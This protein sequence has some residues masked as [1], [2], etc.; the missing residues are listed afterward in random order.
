MEPDYDQNLQ[1]QIAEALRRSREETN[2]DETNLAAAMANS[3]TTR[4]EELARS[5]QREQIQVYEQNLYQNA[6]D[7]DEDVPSPWQHV[8]SQSQR[9]DA[10]SVNHSQSSHSLPYRPTSARPATAQLRDRASSYR[11]PGIP[12]TRRTQAVPGTRLA[13]AVPVS[14]SA[15]MQ[16]RQQ[17]VPGTRLA[18]AVPVSTSENSQ[19]TQQTHPQQTETHHHYISPPAWG[20]SPPSPHHLAGGS[21]P[22]SPQSA[23][24]RNRPL[25][26]LNS[27]APLR[28]ANAS[29]PNT[30]SRDHRSPSS[31]QHNG[32]SPNFTSSLTAIELGPPQLQESPP[33]PPSPSGSPRTYAHALVA[34]VPQH[35]PPSPNTQ[36]RPSQRSQDVPITIPKGEP[37][38]IIDGQ[39]VGR[40]YGG[41]DHIFQ[42][43]GVKLALDYYAAN[44]ICALALLPRNKIDQ[45]TYLRPGVR[46]TLVADDPQL[47]NELHSQG[48]VYFTPAGSHDDFF[49]LTY[50]MRKRADVISNDRFFKELEMQETAEDVRAMKTFL[51]THLIPYTFIGEDFVPNPNPCRLGRNVHQ[52]RALRR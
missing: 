30:P 8:Q 6:S 3:L 1:A 40:D 20:R 29:L 24:P 18:Q 34:N 25:S 14:T 31:P 48:R 2:L 37:T 39:N 17:A 51:E 41:N 27:P 44:G 33:V 26:N 11:G 15:N 22:H 7:E 50:A 23:Y 19:W 28:N 10:P 36:P 52:S 16:R 46:N 5:M 45:R 47:L 49:I 43:R 42:S 32:P 9:T 35:Q 21:G 12:G 38:V 4:D 13:Q